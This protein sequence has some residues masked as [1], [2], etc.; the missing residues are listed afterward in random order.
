M[1]LQNLDYNSAEELMELIRQINTKYYTRLTS[2]ICFIEE[3]ED[4][5]KFV[6]LVTLKDAYSHLVKVFDY[7]LS[8][9]GKQNAKSHLFL[10]VDHL[11]EGLIDTLR[12]IVDLQIKAIKNN[13]PSK[14]FNAIDVQIAQKVA[15]LRVLDK[16]TLDERIEGYQSLFDYLVEIRKKFYSQQ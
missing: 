2:N 5:I 14:D 6:Y 10:Y 4:S 15:E 1:D 3:Y 12:R 9:K 16:I 7:D 11:Q 8:P 13:I